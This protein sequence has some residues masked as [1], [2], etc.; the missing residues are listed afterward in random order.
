MEMKM[1]T[2][3]VNDVEYVKKSDIN[4]NS[5][6]QK[7]DGL[8]LKLIR[9]YS[10]GV[11]YGYLVKKE[12]SIGH[13]KVVLRKAKRIFYWSGACSLSQLAEEGTKNPKDCK[14]AMELSEDLELPNAIEIL[15]ITEKAKKNLDGVAIWKS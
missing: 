8:E 2:I 11:F 13:Y 4:L 15:G 10:S 9:T 12:D 3:T 5:T 7:V 6:A 1:D 14:I